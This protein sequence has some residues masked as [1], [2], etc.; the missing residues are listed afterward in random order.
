MGE[1]ELVKFVDEMSGRAVPDAVKRRQFVRWP[2]PKSVAVGIRQ[3]QRGDLAAMAMACRNIS[4]GGMSLLHR[5][6]IHQGSSIRVC[7][8][9]LSGEI[10]GVDGTV[11]HSRHVRGTTHEI[12]VHF[13][14]PI[15]PREFLSLSAF[16]T[17]FMIEHVEPDDLKGVVLAI[18]D[19][20]ADLRLLQH[21]L[22][23]TQ[24]RFRTAED[25]DE[26]LKLAA[27]GCDLIL[28]DYHLNDDHTGTEFIERLRQSGLDTPVLMT[29]SDTQVTKGLLNTPA[30]AILAK[31]I[32]RELLHR[33][34]A[35]FMLYGSP[36]VAKK[37]TLPEGHPNASFIPDFIADLNEIAVQLE[38]SIK[39]EDYQSCNDLCLRIADTGPTLGFQALA[40]SATKTARL[41]SASMSVSETI[42][43]VRRL[44]TMCREAER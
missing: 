39:T 23:G 25:F 31:P 6:F 13:D 24:I 18:D 1:R 12:G 14:N 37:S 35:Q 41:I 44:I 19:S 21:F 2:Y 8:K 32:A 42:T 16:A 11:V 20:D 30:D 36:S 4:S 28:L 5:A 34:L 22:Q 10:V 26:G 17:T 29:T 33:A 38:E 3:G 7:L 40:D 15:D 27:E 43:P 9:K